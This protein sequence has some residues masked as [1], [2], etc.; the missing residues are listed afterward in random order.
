VFYKK[1]WWFVLEDIIYVLTESKDPKQYIK[2][3]R[4]R[5]E[6]LQKGWVQ[7]VPTLDIKTK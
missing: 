1:E 7:I 6:E 3:M 4:E 2:R 5:D